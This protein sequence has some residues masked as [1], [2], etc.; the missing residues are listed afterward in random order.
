MPD[1]PPNNPVANQPD[2]PKQNR[3]LKGPRRWPWVVLVLILLVGAGIVYLRQRSPKEQ[4]AARGRPGGGQPPLMVSTATAQKGDIGVYVNALGVVTPVNTV[5]VKSRVDGQLVKVH[6]V[7]GQIIHQGDPLLEIDPAPFQAALTQAEGQLARD[8]ALLENARLDLDRYKEALS[9]NAIPKQQLDT[10]VSVVHQ[11]EGAVRLDQGQIDNARVQLAYS[12]IKAPIT[13]RVGLRL[14][15]AGNIV[16]ANDTGPLVTITQVEPIT[17]IFSVAEDY[18]PQ[19]QVQLRQGKQLTVDA[20]DRAQQIRI[21]TGTL[22]TLDNQ[23][24]TTTGTIKLKAQFPNEDLALFPNQFVNARLLV[25]THHGVTLVPNPAI[26]HN[27][28]GAYAYL[29]KPDQTVAVQPVTVGTTDG[30]V[31]EV[32]GLDPGAIIVTDNFNRLV[33]GAKVIVRQA[34]GGGPKNRSGGRPP[35]KGEGRGATNDQPRNDE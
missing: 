12:Y 21:G 24:D 28:Q 25:D 1:Q 2:A 4:P 14:V 20:L 30:T 29:L 32:E 27:A 9:K 6:Y 34:G 15:D 22:Q 13:G 8:T 19:I 16:H 35:G 11:Y 33:E 5:S 10:Q 17:V 23:I 18:L 3:S 7:E 26:Q 31:S